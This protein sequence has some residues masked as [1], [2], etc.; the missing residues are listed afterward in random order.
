MSNK[1]EKLHKRIV[2]VTM[3]DGTICDLQ[4]NS[5]GASKK[6][7]TLLSFLAQ[8]RALFDSI[9]MGSGSQYLVVSTGCYDRK[10]CF[11]NIS[12]P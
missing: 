10:C 8:R 9:A 11:G 1:P 7:K 3:L 6:D 5:F 2:V 4:S 12:R